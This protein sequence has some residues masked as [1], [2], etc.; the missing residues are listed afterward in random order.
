MEPVISNNASTEESLTGDDKI[1]A[2][3][4]RRFKEDETAMS[5]IRSDMLDDLNFAGG[6]QWDQSILR[7][8]TS[9][10]RPTLVINRL[11][12]TICQVVN[13]GKQNRPQIKV[14]PTDKQASEATARV[15]NGMLRHI[16]YDS[17]SEAAFDTAFE[18]AVR[19]GMG[20]FRVATE[21]DGDSFDQIIKIKRI[22]NVFSVYFPVHSCQELDFS[23]ADHCFVVDDM[24]RDQFEEKYGKETVA[25]EWSTISAEYVNRW[26]TKDTVRIAEY[27]RK[28]S[29]KKTIYLLSDGTITDD[30]NDATAGLTVERS[31]EVEDITVKI[32]TMTSFK[33]LDEKEF[34]SRFLPIVPVLGAEMNKG[35]K[36]S[37]FSLI[38]FAK[39]PQRAYNYWKS[40]ECELIALAPKA[41]YLVAD[42]QLEGFETSWSQSNKRNFP[43]LEY[44]TMS[45]QGVP[46]GAPQRQP[47]HVF[48]QAI[49][50]AI[51]EAVDDIKVC[52]GVFDASLGQ[53]SNESSG[54]GIMA[55]QRQSDTANFHFPDNLARS[56]RH[57][58]R[59]VIDMMPEVYDTSRFVRIL[60]E[61]MQQDIVQVNAQ[62]NQGENPNEDGEMYD[63]SCGKYDVLVDTGASYQ[64]KRIESAN[65]MIQLFQSNPQ[66]AMV[67]SDL[68][69]KYLD[70]PLEIQE[71]FKKLLPPNLQDDQQGGKPDPSQL[72]A[73][74]QEE[75]AKVQDLDGVIQRMSVDMQQMQAALHDKSADRA[76]NLEKV[77]VKAQADLARVLAEHDHEINK[78]AIQHG[79][80]TAITGTQYAMKQNEAISVKSLARLVESLNQKVDSL[81]GNSQT[82]GSAGASAQGSAPNGA[83]P[84][85]GS[86][87]MQ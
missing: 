75:Q 39:D 35:G 33:I 24:P 65:M 59:I 3:A 49:N 16:Q 47:Q 40:C 53:R 14:N 12:G 15:I 31:R 64:S 27:F 72:I 73:A 51:S 74:L 26:V 29:T 17:D 25:G 69:A 1:I 42:G 66:L 30:K 6:E 7:D 28:E 41:P 43:Y 5:E 77:V 46:V 2:E 68:L 11:H 54:K 34:P 63:L 37:F 57:A 76:A 50:V 61:D 83:A 52:T 85:N 84:S 62:Y 78:T 58:G 18:S 79:H 23:D 4:L 44:K 67:S 60:G 87:A 10:D 36:V 22:P 80:E 8:R 56:L 70:A 55:R 38:R 20:Y 21:W 9:D 32:Y 81:S 13:D 45:A 19:C 48:D 82:Q 86:P 71:R